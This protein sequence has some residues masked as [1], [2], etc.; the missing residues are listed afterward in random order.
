[1]TT[2]PGESGGDSAI[3]A[4]VGSSDGEETPP[5]T[6]KQ[7]GMYRGASSFGGIVDQI[8]TL[9]HAGGNQRDLEARG[10][11]WTTPKRLRIVLDGNEYR[12]LA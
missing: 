12:A 6:G 11:Y 1:M 4:T 3:S 2:G 7:G 10:R 8:L 5:S 9:R